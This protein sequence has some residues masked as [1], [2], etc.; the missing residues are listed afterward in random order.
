MHEKPEQYHIRML[1]NHIFLLT[2]Q[3]RDSL[4]NTSPAVYVYKCISRP[5]IKF[6]MVQITVETLRHYR[7]DVTSLVLYLFINHQQ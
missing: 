3:L 1:C 5:D 6:R 2:N 4:D 7:T